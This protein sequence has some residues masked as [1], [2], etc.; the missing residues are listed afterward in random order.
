ME[1]KKNKL[2]IMDGMVY[3]EQVSDEGLKYNRLD[4]RTLAHI[5]RTRM[6]GC[7]L[8]NSVPEAYALRDG[9]PLEPVNG[10]DYDE[11]AEAY[12][13]VFQYYIISDDG[14][15]FLQEHTDELVYFV[16]N[17]D[18]Y[19]WGVTHYG[20]S[21][22]YVLTDIELVPWEAYFDDVLS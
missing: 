15:E 7:I 5:L 4:Y 21:W 14:A 8:N 17:F 6:G 13:E 1:N 11:E 18:L 19:L 20:T 10:Y 12:A 9:E 2:P 22:D 16:P 3:G